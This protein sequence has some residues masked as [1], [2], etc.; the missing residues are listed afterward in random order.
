MGAVAFA[1]PYGKEPIAGV[2]PFSQMHG[3]VE[4]FERRDLAEQSKPVRVRL[5]APCAAAATGPTPSP[6]RIVRRPGEAERRDGLFLVLSAMTVLPTSK[7]NRAMTRQTS[8]PQGGF[9]L[10][11]LLVVI[12]IIGVL[13]GLLL[14]AVQQAREAARRAQCVN[15][16][17]QLALALAEL[18]RRHR[19][20]P[21]WLP[22]LQRE[23]V[24]GSTTAS[25]HSI[26]VAV[27]PFLE[28]RSLFDGINFNFTLYNIPNYTI[29]AVGLS[30]VWCPS[31]QRGLSAGHPARWCDV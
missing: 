30:V 20:V 15:N 13:I 18:R 9:T 28:Q 1:W 12:A 31:A 10:I 4:A 27:L 17:K 7:R 22:L 26:F 11:E 24:S 3:F 5:K 16:L 21:H 19:H 2:T 6:C 29:H 14:P 8:I 23:P 25:T